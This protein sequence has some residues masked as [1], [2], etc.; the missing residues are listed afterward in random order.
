MANKRII[1][2]D[3]INEVPVDGYL[4]IDTVTGDTYKILPIKIGAQYTIEDGDH[5]FTL[6]GSNGYSH[7]VD[8]PYDSV[9]MSEAEYNA[10]SEEEKADGTSRFL[11]DKTSTRE[12]ELWTRIGRDVLHTETNVIA[13]AI[14]WLK[15]KLGSG[16]LDTEATD[17]TDAVNELNSSLDIIGTGYTLGSKSVTSVP[18][19]TD[20]VIYGKVL[21]QGKYLFSAKIYCNVN[22]ASCYL[23]CGGL[24]QQLTC[25]N[26]AYMQ[27]CGI[28]TSNGIGETQLHFYQN[29]GSTQTRSDNFD[30][31]YLVR[32]Q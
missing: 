14:N 19:G 25:A 4:A 31:V 28:V 10:L 24:R 32:I 13:K 5:S 9:T 11:Y 29:S 20:T 23:M 22:N 17:I 26:I 8:I 27:L 1:E 21:P 3:T 6:V 15:D 2:L 12:S 7:T 16:D 30:E 18:S